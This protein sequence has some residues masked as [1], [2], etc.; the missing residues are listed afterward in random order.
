M[1]STTGYIVLDAFMEPIRSY[2]SE[3]L[4]MAKMFIYTRP[5]CTLEP[6]KMDLY[7][8]LGECLL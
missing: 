8:E 5:D 1:F 3:Q 2:T 6:V 7:K 4:D